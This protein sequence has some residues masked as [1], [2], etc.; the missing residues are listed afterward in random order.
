MEIKDGV[1]SIPEQ[2]VKKVR[3]YKISLFYAILIVVALFFSIYIFGEFHPVI[4]AV[5]G[6]LFSIPIRLFWQSYMSPILKIKENPE[7]R[8]FPEGEGWSYETNRII[9]ENS[10]NSAAKNCKGYIVYNDNQE[11]VCWTVPKERPNATIN[12]KD[13]GRTLNRCKGQKLN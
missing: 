6:L 11:R 2:E 4:A 10:G 13:E 1:V 3:R 12:A 7:I 9:V 5:G 8:T